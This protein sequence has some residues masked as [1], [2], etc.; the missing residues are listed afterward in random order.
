L[1]PPIETFPRFASFAHPHN[2]SGFSLAVGFVISSVRDSTP[3]SFRVTTASRQLYLGYS[4]GV[5]S[6]LGHAVLSF[7]ALSSFIPCHRRLPFLFSRYPATPLVSNCPAARYFFW[8]GHCFSCTEHLP[9]QRSGSSLPFPPP[10]HVTHSRVHHPWVHLTPC[11]ELLSQ[12]AWAH[13][14]PIPQLRLTTHSKEPV[15]ACRPLSA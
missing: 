7:G 2:F 12:E 3:G 4:L 1:P 6:T 10:L 14:L 8:A 9:L 13:H 5:C 11:C 15:L